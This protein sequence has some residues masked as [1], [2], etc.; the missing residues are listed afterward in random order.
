MDK[1]IFFLSFYVWQQPYGLSRDVS[2]SQHEQLKFCQNQM[3]VCVWRQTYAIWT[4][5]VP[6]ATHHVVVVVG[7]PEIR[8]AAGTEVGFVAFGLVDPLPVEVSPEVD[9]ERSQAAAL[10]WAIET[11]RHAVT[12]IL[13][14]NLRSEGPR[15]GHG[16]W[17]WVTESLW[18]NSRQKKM[19]VQSFPLQREVV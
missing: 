4:K 18:R 19:T 3:Y 5:R 1:R 15:V 9:V 17:Q 8:A 6:I 14:F 16:K 10:V 2:Q 7:A 13:L 11:Q 12:P